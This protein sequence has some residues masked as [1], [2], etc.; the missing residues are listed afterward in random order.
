MLSEFAQELLA[1]GGME[2]FLILSLALIMGHMLGD[3]P[4]QGAFLAS[5]KNRN[6]DSSS[7][8]GTSTVPKGLWVHGLTAHS[9][10]QAGIVW[11]ITGS[12]MVTMIELVVHWITDFSR[13]E[14]W[15]SF[16]TDQ[17]IHVGCKIVFAGLLVTQ[18][19]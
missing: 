7:F 17:A 2:G 9:M 1:R 10:I 13:C 18:V 15:I 8:F 19:V 4:L 6:T 14:E 12:L 11:V 3:Y 5:C 16:N